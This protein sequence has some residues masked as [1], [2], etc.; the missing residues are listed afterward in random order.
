MTDVARAN[1]TFTLEIALCH[2]V[3]NEARAAARWHNAPV[4]RQD[5]ADLALLARGIRRAAFD[6]YVEAYVEALRWGDVT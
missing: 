5:L 4:T 1:E 3:V 2:A 6:Q